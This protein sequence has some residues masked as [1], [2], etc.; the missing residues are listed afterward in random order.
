MSNKAHLRPHKK[1]RQ[2][3][4]TTTLVVV[5]L[6]ALVFVLEIAM[7]ATGHSLPAGRILP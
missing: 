2:T 6:F 4:R 5:L 7:A 1:Q 3:R